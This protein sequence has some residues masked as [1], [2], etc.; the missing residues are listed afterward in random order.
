MPNEEASE[1]QAH[2]VCDEN[3]R[4]ESYLR[5]RAYGLFSWATVPLPKHLED[6]VVR[7]VDEQEADGLPKRPAAPLRIPI[8]GVMVHGTLDMQ[9]GKKRKN[10]MHKRIEQRQTFYSRGQS[11]LG[12]HRVV[13]RKIPTGIANEVADRHHDF[14]VPSKP[15]TDDGQ[16]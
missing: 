2:L 11:H 15:T 6:A 14:R 7:G 9:S 8:A 4:I 5:R 1:Q 10:G 3:L 16:P 12:V 13:H